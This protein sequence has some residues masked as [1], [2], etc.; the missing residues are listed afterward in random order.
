[1]LVRGKCK[2]KMTG[3]KKPAGAGY[4]AGT[5]PRNEAE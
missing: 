5:N 1:M 3:E 4:Y 2:V